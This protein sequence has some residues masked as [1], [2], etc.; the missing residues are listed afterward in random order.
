MFFELE[1]L[2]W[3]IL[4]KRRHSRAMARLF[5]GNPVQKISSKNVNLLCH[6]SLD[7]YMIL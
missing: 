4:K 3:V 7:K 6:H 1:I 2:C 5:K